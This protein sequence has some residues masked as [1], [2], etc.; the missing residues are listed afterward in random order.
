MLWLLFKREQR[1][2]DSVNDWL[3][4][5]QKLEQNKLFNDKLYERRVGL[6]GK[7]AQ[8]IGGRN[9]CSDLNHWEDEVKKI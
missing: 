9:R 5:M 3:S 1:V 4:M 8:G 7:Y 6:L 2:T